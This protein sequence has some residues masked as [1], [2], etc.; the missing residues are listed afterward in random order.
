MPLKDKIS[1]IIDE[2]GFALQFNINVVFIPVFFAIL[3]FVHAWPQEISLPITD[4]SH[5]I[6]GVSTLQNVD[7]SHRVT[8]FY[9]GLFLAMFVFLSLN[10]L[11]NRFLIKIKPAHSEVL[12]M[13]MLSVLGILNI[14]GGMPELEYT[15]MLKAV[16]WL[17][18]ILLLVVIVS[19]F[20]RYSNALSTNQLLYAGL[21]ALNISLSL[22]F[23]GGLSDST[24]LFTSLLV[25][26]FI[27][28][29]YLKRISKSA[30]IHWAFQ[31]RF[32]LFLVP[33]IVFAQEISFIFNQHEWI[34]IHPRFWFLIFIFALW[35]SLFIL[36]RNKGFRKEK[37]SLYR[38]HFPIAIVGIFL[39]ATY[40]PFA[41]A[42]DGLFEMAN[43]ANSLMMFI[44]FNEWPVLDFLPIHLFSDVFYGLL[45]FI[46]NGYDGSM[47]Y[48]AYKFIYNFF[49]IS[50]AFFVLYKIS[51]NALFGFA[52]LVFF[53]YT[54]ILLWSG[55][56]WVIFLIPFALYF[57]YQKPG[58][59]SYLLLLFLVIFQMAWKPDTGF[60]AIWVTALGLLCVFILKKDTF[61]PS[62]LS[63]SLGVFSGICAIALF[64]IVFVFNKSLENI[65][66][67]LSFYA[68]S[69]QARGLADMTNNY[70]RFFS[71][72]HILIPFTLLVLSLF[73]LRKFKLEWN[74]QPFFY[75][76]LL[77]LVLVYF[78]NFQR[79]IT[80]HNFAEGSD[81]NLASYSYLALSFAV[82]MVPLRINVKLI[83]F[84][85]V[86]GTVIFIAK[87]PSQ[88]PVK[89]YLTEII[90]KSKQLPVHS[91][92]RISRVP[93]PEKVIEREV[94]PL[95]QFFQ[96]KL[97]PDQT[98]YDF[99]NTPGLFYYL[100]K[101]PPQYFAHTIAITNERLQNHQIQYLKNNDVPYL[102]YS[103]VPRTWW[104][105]TDGVPNEVRFYAIAE[106]LFQRYRPEKVIGNYFMWKK[107]NEQE[108]YKSRLNP[109]NFK[110]G[111]LPYLLGKQ[112]DTIN[113]SRVDIVQITNSH[114]IEVSLNA[115]TS[116]AFL[117]VKIL[118]P[119]KQNKGFVEY[120]R[121]DTLQGTYEFSMVPSEVPVYYM[122]RL[123]MQYNWFATQ[124]DRILVRFPLQQSKLEKMEL[125][126]NSSKAD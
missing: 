29:L 16:F 4:F 109:Q 5:T 99:S 70:N 8:L 65:P 50:L 7:V 55:S 41:K 1:A 38:I 118:N 13:N 66:A 122:V 43:Q 125:L 39:F 35:A 111:F 100:Q 82:F 24:E 14:I 68:T 69:I 112:N 96:C 54:D 42:P 77:V 19:Y 33:L 90:E 110:L 97:S 72:H 48:L 52:F 98:F 107:T 115:Y 36:G 101:S 11:S 113:Y 76:T 124:P 46:L 67:A 27:F 20:T 108:R 87:Y 28:L 21:L 75:I 32:L 10:Y 49:L 59:F 102:I 119:S 26:V 89:T 56:A 126:I 86:S 60:A 78:S 62:V 37:V 79:G 105:D 83:L 63:K 121:N 6:I 34:R 18:G 23:I 58:V 22:R 9:R 104:D 2:S 25:L 81:W 31:L 114:A 94:D 61:Q 12:S 17:S 40:T 85:L 64:F 73:S 44:K 80:R 45:Y 95:R 116:P 123:S 84:C 117:N 93:M 120:Y 53:P 51:G 103:H 57:V 91:A 88:P 30:F 15:L 106:Y 3:S 71:F 92:K 47:D 74:Q